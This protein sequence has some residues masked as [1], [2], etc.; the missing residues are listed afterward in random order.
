MSGAVNRL[1]RCIV[2]HSFYSKGNGFSVACGDIV[3]VS[4]GSNT[5]FATS[6][7]ER[8]VKALKNGKRYVLYG[9]ISVESRV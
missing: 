8:M 4:D 6:K 7:H 2:F 5:T 9:K 1:H 3:A